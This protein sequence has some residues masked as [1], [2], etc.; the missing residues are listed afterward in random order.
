MNYPSYLVD[1]RQKREVSPRQQSPDLSYIHQKR[2]VSPTHNS[3]IYKPFTSTSKN[4]PIT[5]KEDV[6]SPPKGY[7]S[8]TYTLTTTPL[9]SRTYLVRE[10]IWEFVLFIEKASKL[11]HDPNLSRTRPLSCGIGHQDFQTKFEKKIPQ[12][13]QIKYYEEQEDEEKRHLKVYFNLQ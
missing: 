11:V 3:K 5:R 4:M 1:K 10:I 6:G 8:S 9:E 13:G 7:K 2:S 12:V